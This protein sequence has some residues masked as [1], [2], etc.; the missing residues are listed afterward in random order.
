MK[1]LILSRDPEYCI[2]MATRVLSVLF[3]LYSLWFANGQDCS[4]WSGLCFDNVTECSANLLR[5][6]LVKNCNIK[7]SAN[8]TN[9]ADF[10]TVNIIGGGEDIVIQC[11]GNF[12]D[13]AMSF[14]NLDTLTVEDVTIQYCDKPVVIENVTSVVL[15]NITF[16]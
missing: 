6:T 11:D 5:L 3:L 1:S 8:G 10:E 9:V 14:T 16:R 7:N 4:G 15:R 2:K 13:F 12:V